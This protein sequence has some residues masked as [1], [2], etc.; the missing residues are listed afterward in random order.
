M[1]L[2]YARAYVTHGSLQLFYFYDGENSSP[3]YCLLLDDNAGLY[4]PTMFTY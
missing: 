2:A 1:R 3:S 4:F